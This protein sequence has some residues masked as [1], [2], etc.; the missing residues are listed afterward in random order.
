VNEV[1]VRAADPQ[2]LDALVA[3]LRRAAP[4][5]EV[6]DWRELSPLTHVSQRIYEEFTWVWYL[7]VFLGLAFG[8]VNTLLMAVLERT[9]EFGLLLALGMRPRWILGQVW[10]GPGPG[11]SGGPG[12][13]RRPGGGGRLCLRPRR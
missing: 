4:G 10:L 3:A 13:D 12:G 1:V 8:L 11:Q 5:L 2:R 7:V 6:L 9:R